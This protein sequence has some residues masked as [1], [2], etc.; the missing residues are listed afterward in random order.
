M[1]SGL[2]NEPD[3]INHWHRGHLLSQ[4]MYPHIHTLTYKSTSKGQCAPH[5][6]V[7]KYPYTHTYRHRPSLASSHFSP[8]AGLNPAKPQPCIWPAFHL[9]CKRESAERRSW[10]APG[11][12]LLRQEQLWISDLNLPS[13]K[14]NIISKCMG[15]I[16]LLHGQLPS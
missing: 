6:I 16:P 1:E 12:P 7:I 15:I 5:P 14:V 13:Y 10:W 4:P 8:L 11:C 2:A 3:I 9:S